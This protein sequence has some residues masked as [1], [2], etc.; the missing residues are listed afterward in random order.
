[1]DGFLVYLGGRI[2]EGATFGR[3]AKGVRVYGE[4]LVP[5]VET[6]LR[7]YMYQRNGHANFGDYV[8]SLSD[9][10]LATFAA[11]S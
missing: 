11:Q 10:A 2:G 7:R 9:E 3:K 4:E 5:Y 6:L 1:V 8:N